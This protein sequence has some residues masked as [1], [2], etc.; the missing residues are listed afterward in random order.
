M[1]HGTVKFFDSTQGFG[2]I[3]P[4][5]GSADVFAHVTDLADGL[6]DL[7]EGTRVAFDEGAGRDG[8]LKAVKVKVE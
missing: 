6:D 2:F 8:R 5:D 1:R 3:K 7:S 4:D